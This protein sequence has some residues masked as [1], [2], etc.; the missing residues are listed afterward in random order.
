[1]PTP[2]QSQSL[3]RRAIMAVLLMVGF[4]ALAIFIVLL[5][6]FS[7]VAQLYGGQIFIWLAFMALI[8]AIAII[9]AVFP[10][11]DR[12]NPPWPRLDAKAQ[13]RLFEQLR[14]MA[15]DAK[16]E[17]PAE[18]Y[19]LPESNAWVMSRGGFMGFG[20]RRVMGI[21]FPLM[22]FLNVSE[23]NA[24]LAHELGH[25]YGGD[26]RLGPWIYKTRGAIGRTLSNLSGENMSV[27]SAPFNAYGR[28]FLRVT[29]GISRQQEYTADAFAAGIAGAGSLKTALARLHGYGN[30]YHLYWAGLVEPALKTGYLP[31]IEQ[32]L[33]R[34]FASDVVKRTADALL[35]DA[36]NAQEDEYDTHPALRDRVAA[37]DA[38]P[39]GPAANSDAA[40][41]LLDN[42][43]G[44]WK[45]LLRS[46]SPAH[47][48]K[49]KAIDWT[50]VGERVY[51]DPWRSLR[52]LNR[53][54][55]RDFTAGQL[56]QFF[57]RASEIA[58]ELV[59]HDGLRQERALHGWLIMQVAVSALA[60][61]LP[62]A[63]WTFAVDP[64]RGSAFERDG[65]ST[66]PGQI[67]DGLATGEITEPQWLVLCEA[68]GI[69]DIG[70]AGAIEG[71]SS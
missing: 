7:I 18:V 58:P 45:E 12:F 22:Y 16:Q 6:L 68:L 63:G 33:V 35:E 53:E 37:L 31:N 69:R 27:I 57:Q 55:L 30:V 24:V 8:G 59:S 32:G 13:P 70:L 5:L 23:L 14:A 2:N 20:S 9:V 44:L 48:A 71:S 39:A 36:M 65:K 38:L 46:M 50:E 56:P 17:M 28:M 49:L 3:G 47:F 11:P 19:L 61:T 42:S 60:M 26:T 4:Y 21:G 54:L 34:A 10:R 66:D 62:E 52:D 41:S 15:R 64:A 25:Y 51:V 43:Q 40:L 67:V 1:M 29:H